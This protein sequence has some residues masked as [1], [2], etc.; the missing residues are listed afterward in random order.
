MKVKALKS[1]EGIRDNDRTAKEGKDIYP[2]EG[3]IWE[4]SKE[5]GDFL[6]SHGVVELVEDKKEKELE[7][8]VEEEVVE[9][10]EDLVKEETIEEE[11]PKKK[12]RK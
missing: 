5:R 9:E 6:L 10:T 3:D 2:K 11:K 8:K 4:V 1:F 12:K 7:E